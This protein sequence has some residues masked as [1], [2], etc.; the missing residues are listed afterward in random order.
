MWPSQ[1]K[2]S[3]LSMVKAKL[4][5]HAVEDDIPEDERS[6]GEDNQAIMWPSAANN[7]DVKASGGTEMVEE[8]PFSK[9]N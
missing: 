5:E 2:P 8:I 6:S 4:D 3:A 9:I 7:K 1:K